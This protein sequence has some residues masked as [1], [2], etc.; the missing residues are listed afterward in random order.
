MRELTVQLHLVARLQI[1]LTTTEA[2]CPCRTRPCFACRALTVLYA[3]T[4]CVWAPLLIDQSW[5][6]RTTREISK[7]I[8]DWFTNASAQTGHVSSVGNCPLHPYTCQVCCHPQAWTPRA[9]VQSGHPTAREVHEDTSDVLL[10]RSLSLDSDDSSSD[11]GDEG[12]SEDNSLLTLVSR[13]TMCLLT[14][15]SPHPGTGVFSTSRSSQAISQSLQGVWHLEMWFDRHNAEEDTSHQW[16][17]LDTFFREEGTGK[18]ARVFREGEG[19]SSNRPELGRV[20][21]ALQ[22]PSR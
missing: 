11:C 9:S 7:T 13:R 6:R 10:M 14:L 1:L 8:C 16:A 2:W 17:S 15:S 19:T 3:E 5:C 18:C 4:W 20:V 12:E 21:L 22:S